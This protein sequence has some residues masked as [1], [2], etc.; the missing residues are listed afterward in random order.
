MHDAMNRNPE[1]VGNINRKIEEL[2]TKIKDRILA[3]D[4]YLF[5]LL[6]RLQS[7]GLMYKKNGLTRL[8]LH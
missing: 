1:E 8:T 4:N 5:I 3:Y 7:K 2:Y 6:H